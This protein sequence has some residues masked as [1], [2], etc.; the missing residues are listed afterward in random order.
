MVA[1]SLRNDSIRNL[2]VSKNAPEFKVVYNADD[3]I[4]FDNANQVVYLY[5]NASVEYGSIKL[6]AHKIK[7]FISKN[8]VHAYGKKDSITGRLIEKVIFSDKG[9]EFTAP[10]MYYNFTT[11]KG[12]I[13]QATKQEGEMY[14]LSEVGKKMPNNDIFLSKGKITTCDAEHPHFYFEARKLK[15]I[16]GKKVVVGPTNLVI[17][18]LPTP[19]WVPFGLFPTNS[20]RKSGIL[21]PGYG[22]F[23]GN[24]GLD[25][26][27]FYWAM[28]DYVHATFLT[29]IYF[30]GTTRFSSR[31]AYNKKYKY[32]GTIGIDFNNI[33]RG[34]EELNDFSQTRDFS[35]DWRFKQDVKA[36]PKSSFGAD[37]SY[38][39]PTFNQT[40]NLNPNTATNSV[41]SQSVSQVNWG[42]NAKKWSVTSNA[43]VTQNFSRN[44]VS[45]TLPN[46]N[47]SVR[48]VTRGI[49]TLGGSA[50][51]RN[52]V[53]TGDSTFFTN[54]TLQQFR[55]GATANINLRIAKRVTLLKYLN[56]TLPSLNWNSYFITEEIQKVQ[57]AAGL[58][59]DT[60]N[61]F[62]HA[63]DISLGNVG[64]N[65]KL[66]GTYKFSDDAYIQGLRHTITPSVNVTYRPDF[67]IDAQNINQTAFDTVSQRTIGYSKFSTAT[68]RPNANKAASINFS[69]DQNLQSKVRDNADSTGFGAKKVNIINA[70]R[71]GGSYNFLSDS[72]NWSDLS[73]SLNTAP[74]FLKALNIS[75]NVSP[76]AIDEEGAIYDSLLWKGGS[77]GRLTSFQTNVTMSLVRNQFTK[78]LFGTEVNK[79]KDFSWDVNINYTY[80]YRKPQFEATINQ[81]LGLSGS[82]VLSEGTRFSYNLP[83]N[84]ESFDFARNGYFNFTR[85]LHCWEMTMNWFPFRDDVWYTFTIRPKAGL[86]SDLKYDRNRRGRN[87]N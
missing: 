40:Q 80:Q 10:E 35:F 19:I 57:A 61:R 54:R 13:I 16:P 84:M 59:N 76:Y 45:A 77:I 12:R 8:E 62:Q 73:F 51:M 29:D 7:V 34:T 43:S 56:V 65:T 32:N 71:V 26:L 30:S 24:F 81:S 50:K 36:H 48:P 72:L 37:I 1:D 49:F 67:F 83:V 28:N 75:G 9:D 31:F 38:N 86:L 47:F 2:K 21:I 87:V 4:D 17:Q 60:I 55:N 79:D 82:V 63:Y 27:G 15:V 58:G 33:I 85:T 66:F 39:S 52:E 68:Y 70:F 25:Q 44:T 23:E 42:W 18:D 46:V 3:S 11:K 69:V 53:A 6:I 22:Q 74:A 14:L 64:L 41:Q 5:G 20:K 78:L